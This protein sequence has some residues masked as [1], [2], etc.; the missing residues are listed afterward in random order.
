MRESV[1]SLR[2]KRRIPNGTHQGSQERNTARAV[3]SS[4]QAHHGRR[5]PARG[6]ASNQAEGGVVAPVVVL[7][8][9]SQSMTAEVSSGQRKEGGHR[10]PDESCRSEESAAF[11]DL[12]SATH[13]KAKQHTCEVDPLF[14]KDRG[15]I[16][17][18]SSLGRQDWCPTSRWETPAVAIRQ[19]SLCLITRFKDKLTSSNGVPSR[20]KFQEIC[21]KKGAKVSKQWPSS[22]TK[23]DQTCMLPPKPRVWLSPGC[24]DIELALE[25]NRSSHRPKIWTLGL[26]AP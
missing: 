3:S 22:G 2:R 23:I 7:A 18:D 26:T 5:K 15:R 10:K 14:R 4:H 11:F 8:I 12:N 17:D 9:S 25:R 1:I 20:F 6:W 13:P 24:K 21:T 19:I 16:E